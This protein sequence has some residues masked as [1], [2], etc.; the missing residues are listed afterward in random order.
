MAAKRAM[1]AAM[2]ETKS[3]TVAMA[4][5]R[6]AVL[7]TTSVRVMAAATTHAEILVDPYS[8]MSPLPIIGNFPCLAVSPKNTSY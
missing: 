4:E 3:T 1:V 6:A 5:L 7:A 8:K 2:V